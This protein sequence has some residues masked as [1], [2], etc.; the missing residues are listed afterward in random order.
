MDKYMPNSRDD[1]LGDWYEEYRRLIYHHIQNRLRCSREEAEDCTSE[2]FRRASR[3]LKGGGKPV[4]NPKK[5]LVRIA[6]S[7]CADYYRANTGNYEIVSAHYLTSGEE[8][9]SL[10]DDLECAEDDRPEVIAEKHALWEEAMKYLHELPSEQREAIEM[11]Y[12]KEW[13]LERIAKAM[14]KSRSTIQG[15]IRKGIGQLR[16]RLLRVDF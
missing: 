13:N 11:R 15:D 1:P 2:V 9:G 4:V 6:D 3:T 7:V 10:L 5:W 8:E 14:G 12:L 16:A